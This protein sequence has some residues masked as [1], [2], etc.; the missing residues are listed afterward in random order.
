M[1]NP[2]APDPKPKSDAAILC[3]C[4]GGGL[5]ALSWLFGIVAVML[6]GVDGA[7]SPGGIAFFV[8]LAAA[9]GAGF[10]LIAIGGRQLLKR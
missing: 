4:I 7:L 5:C 8:A 9:T 6:V 10:V 1:T 2:D 3:F